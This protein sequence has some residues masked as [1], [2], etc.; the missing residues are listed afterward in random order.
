L[1][2]C[3]I[4]QVTGSAYYIDGTYKITYQGFP[5]LIVGTTDMNREFHP[6]GLMITKREKVYIYCH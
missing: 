6:F 2:Q 5:L 1:K 3:D 4:Y